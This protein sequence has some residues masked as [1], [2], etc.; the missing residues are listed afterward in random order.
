L[1]QVAGVLAGAVVLINLPVVPGTDYMRGGATAVLVTGFLWLTSWVAWVSSG[2]AFRIQGTF[3]EET[4]TETMRRSSHVFDVVASLKFGRE[5]VDQVLISPAGVVAVETKWRARPPSEDQLISDADQASR[6]ARSLRNTLASV[7]TSGLP[8]D[9]V[10][11]AL[12]VCGPGRKGVSSRRI[13]TG[14]GPVD[15][16]T[17]ADLHSWLE[18]RGHGVVGPDFAEILAAELHGIARGRDRAAV[19]AGPLIR[20]LARER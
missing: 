12:V 1:A 8:P 18:R 3:A 6:A 9:L 2:L 13:Q 16:I 5:D 20:W 15:V 11:A 4:V 14:L 10:T 7:R 17:L 19:S